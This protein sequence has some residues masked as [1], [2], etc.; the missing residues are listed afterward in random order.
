MIGYTEQQNL[1]AC[2]VT[3]A[4]GTEEVQPILFGTRPCVTELNTGGWIV[5]SCKVA[6]NGDNWSV[7]TARI[8]LSSEKPLDGSLLPPLPDVSKYRGGQYPYLS[9]FD[10][11]RIYAGWV[12]NE[13]SVLDASLLTEVPFPIPDTELKPREGA[14]LVPIFWGFI[15]K[16]ELTMDKNGYTIIISCRDRMELLTDTRVLSN[17]DFLF[18]NSDVEEGV[19]KGD[20]ANAIREILNFATGFSPIPVE[21]GISTNSC[22]KQFKVGMTVRGY[23][24]SAEGKVQPLFKGLRAP[25]T[26]AVISTIE[27]LNKLDVGDEILDPSKWVRAALFSPKDS[28]SNPRTHIWSEGPPLMQGHGAAAY[29]FINQTPFDVIN[30]AFITKESRPLDVFFS[31]VNGDFIIAPNATDTSGYEDDS[32]HYRTY[33]AGASPTSSQCPSEPQQIQAM[34]VMSSNI[35]TFNRYVITDDASNGGGQSWIEAIEVT[36]QATPLKYAQRNPSIPCRVQVIEDKNLSAYQDVGISKEAAAML[37]GASAAKRYSRDI[38]AVGITVLGDPTWYMNESFQ[39]WNTLLHDRFIL[40]SYDTV[41]EEKLTADTKQSITNLSDKAREWVKEQKNGLNRFIP[42]P[43]GSAAVGKLLNSHANST[44]GALNNINSGRII[45]DAD[46]VILPKYKARSIVHEIDA[47]K[48]YL[49][50][51][52]GVSE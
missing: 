47:R 30:S 32:R 21:S 52:E 20:R 17:P 15:D 45:S 25:A 4:T 10:E 36:L 29:T 3:L 27:K 8:I 37:V 46:N 2:V 16:M 38:N 43:E 40:T 23:E 39:V 50:T 49:T 5:R 34:R 44:D 6:I 13:D 35:A 24:L 41:A 42:F 26:E 31:H 51:I 22:W 7:G 19:V 12:S 48:G 11:I 28:N 18:D 33:F 14:R 9:E 1:P